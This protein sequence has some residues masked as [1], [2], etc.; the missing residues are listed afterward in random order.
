MSID[1]KIRGSTKPGFSLPLKEALRFSSHFAGICYLRET[2]DA[3]LGEPLQS[4]R[5]RIGRTLKSG[6]HSVY[7]HPTYNLEITGMP[8]ALVMVLNNEKVLVTSEKSARYTQ[9]DPSP[10]EKELYDKWLP[11]FQARILDTYPDIG[12]EKASKLAQENARYLTSVFTPTIMGHTLNLRQLNYVMHW[13]NDFVTNA[14][15]TPFNQRLKPS[16]EEFNEA[17]EHLYVERL[18]PD[19]RFRNLSL[20]SS[21]ERQEEFGEHYSINYEGTFAQLAQAHRHRTLYYEITDLEDKPTKFFVPPILA[22]DPTLVE[23]WLRDIESVAQHYP[24]GSLIP[25]NERGNWENLISKLGER[26]CGHAQLETASRTKETLDRYIAEVETS[27]PE[28]HKILSQY[29]KG[30]RCTFPDYKCASACSFGR[31]S[32]ERLI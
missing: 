3:I 32:L 15:D 21:M 12:E 1:V 13:F 10:E 20:F 30:P 31:K 19:V 17:L 25:I 9:M 18:D 23:K 8:K 11:I 6:H 4:T 2:F 28:I 22:S 5:A 24:Q 29:G 27:H 26:L 16:M 7:G 14:P